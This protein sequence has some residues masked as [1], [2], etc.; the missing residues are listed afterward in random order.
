MEN[1]SAT[2]RIERKKNLLA[3]VEVIMPVWSK[4][5]G[6]GFLEISLPLLNISTWAKDEDDSEIAI[7]E[8]VAGFCWVCEKHGKGLDKELEHLGW[9]KDQKNSAET[10][11]N[12]ESESILFE[13]LL[14]TGESKH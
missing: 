6:D 2:I 8:A 4:K 7:Q 10:F 9:H 13:S 5:S 1:N 11:F 3:A 14:N 12:L